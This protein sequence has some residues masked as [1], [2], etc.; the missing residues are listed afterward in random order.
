MKGGQGGWLRQA[1]KVFQSKTARAK[2]TKRA[3]LEA[4][5]Y[6]NVTFWAFLG[7]FFA[8]KARIVKIGKG[9]AQKQGQFL[10]VFAKKNDLYPFISKNMRF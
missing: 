1:K 7:V 2:P 9:P 4:K 3:D 8:S 6:I 10:A 5:S